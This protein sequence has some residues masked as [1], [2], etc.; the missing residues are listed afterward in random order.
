[1]TEEITI[2]ICVCTFRREYVTKTL[3]SLSDISILDNWNVNIIVVDNDDTDSARYTIDSI[4]SKIRFPIS[5]IHAPSRNISIARNACLDASTSQYL[6]FIDD[7]S[8]ASQEW[9]RELVNEQKTTNCDAVLGPVKPI[10]QEKPP[11]WIIQGSFHTTLPVWVNG[12]ITTGYA[13]NLLLLRKSPYIQN[14]KFRVESGKT[15]GEDTFY[16]NDMFTLGG[17]ISYAQYALVFETV[18]YQRTSL[19]WL[20]KRRF[21][22]GQTHGMLLVRDI[23][24]NSFLKM[25]H[26]ALASIKSIF[27]ILMSIIF[28]A[29]KVK[30]ISW[31]L[32]GVFHCG[33]VMK[34]FGQKVLVQYGY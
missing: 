20:I 19:K 2:D 14:L 15:G 34:L 13:G 16:L 32:R 8:I 24:K 10:Y 17:K 33:V 1:M 31:L 30:S 28:V 9:L 7:D 5:Y 25:K 23:N 11:S 4:R 26:I 6:A 3:E 22:S 29:Y 12:T 27:C 18:P 21:R